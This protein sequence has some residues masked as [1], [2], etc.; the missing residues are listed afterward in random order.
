MTYPTEFRSE[1]FKWK[2]SD[3]ETAELQ[4]IGID[5]G[6]PILIPMYKRPMR[7]TGAVVHA[8]DRGEPENAYTRAGGQRGLLEAA[9]RFAQE[10]ENSKS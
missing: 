6:K 5:P 9:H 10:Y 3:P 8:P 7:P 1:H 2:N 4:Y